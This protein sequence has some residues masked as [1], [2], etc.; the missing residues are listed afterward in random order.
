VP[1]TVRK[2]VVRDVPAI[3]KLVNEYASQGIML[4]RSLHSLYEHIRDYFVAV[5][6]DQVVGCAA[7][8]VSWGD[9]AEIR[10]LAVTD[11]WLG[12]GVGR[13]LVVE[14][15]AEARAFGIERVFVLTFAADFFDHLGFRLVDKAE[16]PHKIWQECIDCIHFP[17]CSEVAMVMEVAASEGAATPSSQAGAPL[18]CT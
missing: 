6:G 10:S 18:R 12:Q 13:E 15:L 2:A 5:D 8:H 7:M 1:L 9:L 17:D 14:A 11:A 16:L 3:Q 4:P